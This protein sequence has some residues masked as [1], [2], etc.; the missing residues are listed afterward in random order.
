MTFNEARRIA[1]AAVRVP[2]AASGRSGDGWFF[3][4][5]ARPG[6]GGVAGVL[7]DGATGE[8][9]PVGSREART[10]HRGTTAAN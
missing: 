1:V 10:L 4:P 7:V 6:F 3:I 5:V 8:A 2:L 9:R